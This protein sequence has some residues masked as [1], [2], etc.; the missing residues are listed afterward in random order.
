MPNK[1][2][3]RKSLSANS[4]KQRSLLPT[5]LRSGRITRSQSQRSRPS[6][7]SNNEAPIPF[8][9]S[10][11]AELVKPR[12]PTT[13][14]P[15]SDHNVESLRSNSRFSDPFSPA[16]QSTAG[17]PVQE[18]T[19]EDAVIRN[20]IELSPTRPSEV[21]DHKKYTVLTK[22]QTKRILCPDKQEK[23]IGWCVCAALGTKQ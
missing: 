23:I 21:S 13:T 12:R 19:A 7:C 6:S 15:Q 11:S 18:Y 22:I 10:P 4:Q 20:L 3:K 2:T 16:P 1:V 14:K 17:D 5:P 8:N 9:I